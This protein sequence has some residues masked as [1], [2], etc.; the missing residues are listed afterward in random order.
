MEATSARSFS[1]DSFCLTPAKRGDVHCHRCPDKVTR[2]ELYSRQCCICIYMYVCMVYVCMYVCMCSQPHI[3]GGVPDT[4]ADAAG[5]L[6]ITVV[7]YRAQI[8]VWHRH[9]MPATNTHATG[10]LC[11]LL[12]H[13]HVQG[14]VPK[15]HSG[16]IYDQSQWRPVARL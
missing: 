2:R 1:A 8:T 5:S 15:E 9:C 4:R 3:A 12:Q 10:V 7:R 14:R 13:L 11:L 16:V 6:P